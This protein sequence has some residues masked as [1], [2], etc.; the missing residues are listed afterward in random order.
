MATKKKKED[1]DVERAKKNLGVKSKGKGKKAV[2][3]R[4]RDDGQLLC[5]EHVTEHQR[6]DVDKVTPKAGECCSID[7]DPGF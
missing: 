4:L 7:D 6:V 2:A 5:D 3:W 1:A